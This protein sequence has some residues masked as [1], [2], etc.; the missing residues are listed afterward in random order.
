V[1]SVSDM[2]YVDIKPD[3]DIQDYHEVKPESSVSSFVSY[4]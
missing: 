2:E 1:F 3:V 4:P